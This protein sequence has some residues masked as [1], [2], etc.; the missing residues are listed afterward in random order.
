[1]FIINFSHYLLNQIKNQI[2]TLKYKFGIK[3]K[4]NNSNSELHEEFSLAAP[5]EK[6]RTYI[7][8]PSAGLQGQGLLYFIFFLFFFSFYF[9]CRYLSCSNSFGY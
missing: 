4:H 3:N 1:M 2:Q 5:D 7:V 8:K 9:F 6:P